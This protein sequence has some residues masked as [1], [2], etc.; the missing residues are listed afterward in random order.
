MIVSVQSA[1]LG[2]SVMLIR[3]LAVFLVAASVMAG[4]VY[5]KSHPRKP[6]EQVNTTIIRPVE[7]SM[8][9]MVQD[10]VSMRNISVEIEGNTYY[11]CCPN[12]VGKL[13]LTRAIRYARDMVTGKVV[14]KSKAFVAAREDGSVVYFESE[15]TAL[16]YYDVVHTASHEDRGRVRFFLSFF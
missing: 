3:T 4:V 12:C 8:I 11:G 13:M 2:E 5:H 15:K 9:C 10:R 16:E 1:R 14:D 7:H 6:S